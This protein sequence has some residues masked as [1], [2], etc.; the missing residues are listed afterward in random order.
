MSKST[1]FLPILKLP[2]IFDSRSATNFSFYNVGV[3]AVLRFTAL[4]TKLCPSGNSRER[5]TVG[6]M[7]ARSERRAL[8]CSHISFWENMNT[9]KLKH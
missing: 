7:V 4:Q 2:D 3:L 1:E 8:I 6:S 5:G 9:Q